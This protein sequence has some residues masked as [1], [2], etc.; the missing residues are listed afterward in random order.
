[1]LD[2]DSI[3]WRKDR[4]IS[5]LFRKF[6]VINPKWQMKRLFSLAFLLL[7]SLSS[8]AQI[9]EGDREWLNHI[10]TDHP[11]M[12]LTAED[13]PQITRAAQG[14]ENNSFRTMQKQIDHLIKQGVEFKNP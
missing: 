13:I 6:A 10:R 5:N 14:Y 3:L 11:R 7:A 2:Y 12:F 8:F 4:K 9:K 1:M